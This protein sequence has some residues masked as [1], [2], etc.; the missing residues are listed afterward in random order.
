[1]RVLYFLLHVCLPLISLGNNAIPAH[2]HVV[3]FNTPTFNHETKNFTGLDINDDINLSLMEDT[4]ND[5]DEESQ[6]HEE[7]NEENE[8]RFSGHKYALQQKWHSSFGSYFISD[9]YS[10]S[11]RSFKKLF[12]NSTAVYI[13]YR[14]LRI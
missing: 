6:H 8:L 4:D 10:K 9:Y 14:V 13:T 12:A 3:H 1:M 2:H 5:I 11:G 7:S